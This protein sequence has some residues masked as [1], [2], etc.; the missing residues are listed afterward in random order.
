M[1]QILELTFANKEDSLSVRSFVVREHLSEPF[2]IDVV[3]RSPV[4]ALDL[5]S[6]VGHGATFRILGDARDGTR[7]RTWT[8]LCSHMEEVQAEETGLSTYRLRVVPLLWRT[9]L[10]TNCRVFE[11]QKIPDI[12]QKVLSEWQIVPVLRLKEDYVK[13]EYRVQYDETDF[14]FVSRLLEEAG[15]SYYFEFSESK[16]ELVLSDDV[17][18]GPARDGGPLPYKEGHTHEGRKDFATKAKVATHVRPGLFSL[19]DHDF[20]LKPDYPLVQEHKHGIGLEVMLERYRYEPGSFWVESTGPSLP[21]ADYKGLYKSKEDHGKLVARLSLE[22]ERTGRRGVEFET[23]A[24]DLSP[25]KTLFLEEHPRPDLGEKLVVLATTMRGTQA[26]EFEFEIAA[27][28]AA[29]PVRPPRVTPRPRVR[30]VQ[31][32]IV[33]G[34]PGE[35]IHTDEFGRVRVHFHWDREH[36]YDSDDSSCWLRVSQG[37]AGRGFGLITIPRVGQEVLVDFFDGDPDRPVVTGRVFNST[38]RVPYALPENKTKSGFRSD[39]TPGSG[40][41]NEL[42]FEDKRGAEELHI[43]AERDYSEVIK[44]NQSSTVLASRSASIGSSNSITVGASHSVNVGDSESRVVKKAL[45]QDVGEL[46]AIH[47]ASGTGTEIRDKS[48]ISSTGGAMIIL[49]GDDIL[50]QAKGKITLLANDLAR[51]HGKNEVQIEGGQTFI[52]CSQPGTAETFGFAEAREPAGPGSGGATNDSRMAVSGNAPATPPGTIDE[53]V[54]NAFVPRPP[55]RSAADAPAGL[56]ID[57]AAAQTIAEAVA[58]QSPRSVAEAV[59]GVL[60]SD[61][62]ERGLAVATAVRD[63]RA[64]GGA[65]LLELPELRG[66]LGA[67][68]ES[69]VVGELTGRELLELVQA[70]KKLAMW[71]T[72]A[73]QALEAL[74]A[75]PAPTAPTAA[76]DQPAVPAAAKGLMQVL[77]LKT[78]A[79]PRDLTAAPVVAAL[80][81]A[82][83]ENVAGGLTATAAR[84]KG[85]AEHGVALYAGDLT[86]RFAKIRF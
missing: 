20:R 7:I 43:Q 54:P 30:G 6:F 62:L 38:A 17:G 8:G 37:W 21:H 2:A 10:R 29:D 60:R 14:A 85:L 40:G 70:G 63:L 78:D 71:H 45:T 16:T 55:P 27:L 34:P 18:N 76:A 39:S 65:S 74:A 33:V 67:V 24:V 77:A 1:S 58:S 61:A 41:Y 42:S 23:N 19:R 64:T 84:A 79:A 5:E 49:D 75:I 57:A 59:I 3:A 48:I 25:G 11:R 31:S 47:V 44:R 53:A 35:E 80:D 83:E 46:H 36:P 50:I 28:F 72:P 9:R 26:G 12:V 4:T 51:L 56:A 32:A 52:N 86:G 69:P 66:A 68:L 73:D 15:I 22:S 82:I 13:H 81:A